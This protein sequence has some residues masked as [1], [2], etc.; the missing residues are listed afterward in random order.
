[1]K[2]YGTNLTMQG[3]MLADKLT[4]ETGTSF[5]GPYAVIGWIENGEITAIA[6]FD[7][8][9]FANIDLHIWGPNKLTRQRIRDVLRYVFE[10]LE[11]N[12]LTARIDSSNENLLQLIKRTGF[13]YECTMTG[14]LGTAAAPR[15]M[16]IY[17]ITSAQA[18]E[19]IM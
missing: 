2:A 5:Y 4:R 9:T 8:Y 7:N 16:H 15:D 18:S 14:M 6:A 17:K 13:V 12:R 11:C 10:Q 19:W 3:Q 1:M